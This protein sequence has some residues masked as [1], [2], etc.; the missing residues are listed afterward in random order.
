MPDHRT[1]LQEQKAPRKES[2]MTD[3]V[4]GQVGQQLGNYQLIRLLGQG[5]FAEVYLSEHVYL[6]TQAAIKV[7]HTPLS[8]ADQESFLDEARTIARL[9]HPH[10][11]P[12]LECG[13]ERSIPFL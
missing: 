1:S 3:L 13:V 5:S 12:V 9:K 10:I 2:Q 6:K 4:G 7:L 8:Q 11:V